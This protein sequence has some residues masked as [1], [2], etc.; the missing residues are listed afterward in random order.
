MSNKVEE[1]QYEWTSA[2]CFVL[3]TIAIAAMVITSVYMV[4]DV[5]DSKTSQPT[6]TVV[7]SPIQRLKNLIDSLPEDSVLRSN[8][9]VVLGAEYCEDTNDLNELLITYAE[10]KIKQLEKDS[11]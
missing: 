2:V 7:G 6:L 3:L 10:F 4:N 5:K 8:L 11:K 9:S 1:K